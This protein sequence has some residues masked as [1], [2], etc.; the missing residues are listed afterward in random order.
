MKQFETIIGLEIHAQLKT[1]SKMFCSCDNYSVDSEP[2]INTCPI[3]LGMPG[4]LPVANVQAI[5][6]TY[7]FGL[8]LNAKIADRFNF[9]RKNYFYPDLPK[10]YQITSSTNPPAIGGYLEIE[11][12]NA[13]KMIRINHIHL[14]EDAG[15][16]IHPS[17]SQH[18]LVDLNR[19][20]TPLI[21]IVTE[22]DIRSPYQARI[23][24]QDLRSLLRYLGISD[25]N[26]E[27]GNLR[28]DANIS[29]RPYEQEKLGVKVEIKN[30]NSFKMIERALLYEQERQAELLNENKKI[31]QETRG[32]NEAKG[33]TIGQRSKE[34]ANDYRY[35]PEPD[36][37]HFEP[38]NDSKFDLLKIKNK[39]PEL[40]RE[41]KLRFQEEYGLTITDAETLTSDLELAH[42]FESTIVEIPETAEND[43]VKR[44]KAK[45][46][47]NWIIS[48][49]LAKLAGPL[50]QSLISSS[51]L[52]ELIESIDSGQISG[53]MAKEIF[54]EMFKT[55]KM[56]KELI[57]A[58]G[59]VQITD[60]TFLG[61]TI[62]RVL[63]KN[64]GPVADYQK[65]KLQAFGFLVGQVMSETKGKASPKLVNELLKE[66]LAEKE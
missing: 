4:T 14:E 26:M 15:K 63:A 60:Q 29:L 54:S 32:W 8:A 21:E 46:I 58:S 33:K 7:F 20:G 25:A 35:L 53:K 18:S 9:E 55:G 43:G 49:L 52:A 36:L 19:A 10:A 30:M 56:P 1:D 48:E 6:W 44:E 66:R 22:P 39:L 42:F 62:D 51:G 16:L 23:F 57:Q 47:A 28:C 37:P 64:K 59:M 40:P 11:D 5:E 41:K 61:K 13:L 3:C 38:E 2:N 27:Q 31:V 34:E 50:S 17:G 24:M 65:G 12:D 45:K